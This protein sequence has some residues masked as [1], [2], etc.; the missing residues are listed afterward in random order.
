MK[1]TEEKNAGGMHF[2]HQG[3]LDQ[4]SLLWRN[5]AKENNKTSYDNS[6]QIPALPIVSKADGVN[7]FCI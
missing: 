3:E 1:E 5:K 6:N 7:I 4:D 2:N